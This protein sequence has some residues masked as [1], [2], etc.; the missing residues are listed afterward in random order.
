MLNIIYFWW[1]PGK[2]TSVPQTM[3]IYLAMPTAISLPCSLSRHILNEKIR[4]SVW[5]SE[6]A[7]VYSLLEVM[8]AV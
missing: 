7:S 5:W 4:I 8:L 1:G 3:E 2:P 6:L